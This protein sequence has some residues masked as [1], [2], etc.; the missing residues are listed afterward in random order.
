[1]A[2]SEVATEI[3][4][5]QSMMD[6]LGVPVLLPIEVKVDNVEAIYLSKSATTSNRT[7]H[8]DTRYHFVRD[9]IDDGILKSVFVRSEDN[10]ADIMT[11]NLSVKLYEQHSDAIMNGT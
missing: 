11:K 1:M 3:L 4:F 9:Y 8:I 7:R 6:F 5:M 2:V 10:H